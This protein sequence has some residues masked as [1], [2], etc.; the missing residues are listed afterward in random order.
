M[1]DFSKLSDAELR[2]I[3]GLAPDAPIPEPKKPWS[4]TILPLSED[5]Q[6]KIQF[7]SNAGIV[8]G[9]KR[10]F[11]LPGQVYKGEINPASP[12]GVGRAIEAAGIYSPVSTVTRAG[13]N[14]FGYPTDKTLV[15]ARPKAPATEALYG[16][17]DDAYARARSLGVEYEPKSVADM[18]N[19]TRS[20]LEQE[21]LFAEV[22]PRTFKILDNLSSVPSAGAGDRVTVPYT[23]LETARKLAGRV[24]RKAQSGEDQEAARRVVGAIDDFLEKGDPSSVVAGPAAAVSQVAR[25]ARGNYAAAKRSDNITGIGDYAELRALASNSGRNL[26][27]SIRQ[28]VADLFNPQHPE[29]LLGFTPNEVAGL[30]S[31][32]E[33]TQTRNR[34]RDFGNAFGGGGG[35]GA[36]IVGGLAGSQTGSAYGTL[37]GALMGLGVPVAGMSARTAGGIMTRNAANKVAETTRKRS[38]LYEALVKD[39]PMEAVSPEGR[40]AI[41]RALMQAQQDQQQ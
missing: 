4:A 7:D 30:K 16:A 19:A 39:L 15:P 11:T 6:G 3:A 35:V 26:D 25:E 23:G 12:E 38:P 32:V 36:S 28:R 17:S 41:I 24:S 31:V 8:G 22:A 1:D 29:R 2:R 20:A 40:A 5:A 9:I 37:V 33:G 14:V 34:L 10:A 13:G 21:A 18:A 27:N